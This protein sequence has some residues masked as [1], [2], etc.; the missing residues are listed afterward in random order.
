MSKK[1]NKKL[2]AKFY[3]GIATDEE[4]KQ[5]YNSDE[6]DSMLKE[7]WDDYSDLKSEHG[8]D[9]QK[10]TKGINARLISQQKSTPKVR[11]LANFLVKHAAS[12]VIPLLAVGALYFLLVLR[13]GM[14]NNV[15]MV[16]KYNPKGQRTELTLPDGSRVWLNAA[17]KITYPEKF[18]GN[19]RT[20]TLE[21]EAFFEVV[22]NAKKPFIVKTDKLDIEVLGTSFNVMAYS[23]DKTIQTTLVTGKVS[24]KRVNPETKK[25]QKAILTPNHQAVFYKEDERF[26]LDQVDTKKYTSWKQGII[27]FDNDPFYRVVHV[28]ER[29]YDIDIQVDQELNQKYNYTIT[30]TDESLDEVLRLIKKTTPNLNIKR[31]TNQVI[32]TTN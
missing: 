22:K 21:G 17:T 2:F 29:W 13:P 9:H 19:N 12:I 14:I 11:K 8:I 4:K 7:Q 18:I 27:V 15:A 10:I 1:I 16:E 25:A 26:V 3:W 20:I 5:V 24:V 6:S 30:I 28:L 31:N 32:V 23:E